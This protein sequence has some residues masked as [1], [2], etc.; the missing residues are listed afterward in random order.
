MIWKQIN[1]EKLRERYISQKVRDKI[2]DD[3]LSLVKFLLKVWLI[4]KT[5]IK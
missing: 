1:E 4:L 3:E 5:L 2:I